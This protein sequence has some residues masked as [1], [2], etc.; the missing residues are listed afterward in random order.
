MA[1][2]R[3]GRLT[4]RSHGKDQNIDEPPDWRKLGLPALPR[5][6]WQGNCYCPYQTSALTDSQRH[7]HSSHLQ[8]A[9]SEIHKLISVKE[10]DVA[11]EYWTSIHMLE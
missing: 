5:R 3:E 9:S 6:N 11:G 10:P 4:G 7:V 1:V 8:E 2:V